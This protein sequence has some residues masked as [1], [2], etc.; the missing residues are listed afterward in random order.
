MKT[1]KERNSC[2]IHKIRLVSDGQNI[3]NTLDNSFHFFQFLVQLPKTEI[4]KLV[5]LKFYIKNSSLNEYCQKYTIHAFIKLNHGCLISDSKYF[6]LMKTLFP[7]N[8]TKWSK[9]IIKPTKHINADL[10]SI[11]YHPDSELYIKNYKLL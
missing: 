10:S 11:R 1:A 6:K 7:V 9:Q 8:T 3:I 4:C 5:K 2:F